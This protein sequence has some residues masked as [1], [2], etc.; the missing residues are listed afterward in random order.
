M[1][2][3]IEQEKQFE[4]R[5]TLLLVVSILSLVSMGWAVLGN[6]SSLIRGPES[7]ENIELAKVEL[8]KNI[9]QFKELGA[10]WAVSFVKNAMNY[11]EVANNNHNLNVLS[12]IIITLIGIGGVVMMLRRK[13]LGFHFYIIYSFLAS[14]QVYLFAKPNS[15]TN[16]VV[17][18]SLIISAVFV[19]LYSRNLKWLK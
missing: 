5:P 2:E 7:A 12:T 11:I 9:S 10:D 16:F 19:I 8:S 4:K 18:Y 6:I 14:V 1:S 15:F 17:I 3:I 13:K